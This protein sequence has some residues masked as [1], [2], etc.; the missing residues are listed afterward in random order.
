[1][2]VKITKVNFLMLNFKNVILKSLTKNGI[3]SL[4][5]DIIIYMMERAKSLVREKGVYS[6]PEAYTGHPIH[7]MAEKKPLPIHWPVASSNLIC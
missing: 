4:F 3:P 1:M 2:G 6:E 7:E 5:P